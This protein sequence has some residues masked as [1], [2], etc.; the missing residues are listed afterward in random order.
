VT[1][2]ACAALLPAGAHFCPSCGAQVGAHALGRTEVRKTV[3]V[4]FCDMVGS[5]ALSQ[6]LD[7]EPLHMLMQQYF[8]LMRD[9]LQRHGGFVEKYIGDAVVAIFGVPT[10]HEDDALRAVRAAAEMQAAIVRLSKQTEREF[11]VPLSVRIGVNTGPVIAVAPGDAQ[12]TVVGETVNVAA[13]LEQHADPGQVLLGELTCQAVRGTAEFSMGEPLALKGIAHPVTPGRLVAITSVSHR[14]S[15]QPDRAFVDRRTEVA[16]LHTA[17]RH[18]VGEQRLRMVILHGDP[19]I[20]KSRL[21]R[22]FTEWARKAGAVVGEGHCPGYGSGGS[23]LALA[24]ALRQVLKDQTSTSPEFAEASKIL[25][26]SLLA[27]GSPG[28]VPS[29]TA[30]AV[31]TVLTEIGRVRPVVLI[32][33]DLHW[34]DS[35]LLAVIAGLVGRPGGIPAVMLCLGR[36]EFAA[37]QAGWVGDLPNVQSAMVGPL[38]E[39]ACLQLAAAL[40]EVVAHGADV[41]K[42]AVRRAEGNPLYVEQFITAG[43]TEVTPA[44][45]LYVAGPV[46]G[47]SGSRD[48]TPIPVTVS[49]LIAY[50]LDLL[51]AAER[52]VLSLGAVCGRWFTLREVIAAADP[53]TMPWRAAARSGGLQAVELE[54][55]LDSLAGRRLIQPSAPPADGYRFDSA[56]IHEV[57]YGSIPKRRRAAAHERL[58]RWLADS[59]GHG[60]D[61]GTDAESIGSHWERAWQLRRELRLPKATYWALASRGAEALEAAGTASLAN[62][63]PRHAIGL[64]DRAMVLAQAGAPDGMQITEASN[65]GIGSGSRIPR[66]LLKAGEARLVVGDIQAGRQLIEDADDQASATDDHLVKAHAE[67]QLA[68]LNPVGQFTRSLAAARRALPVFEAAGDRLGAA[69]ALLRIGIVEQSRGRHVRAVAAMER[70]LAEAR[71]LDAELEHATVVGALGVSLWLGPQQAA[72]AIGTCR[73]LL[74]ADAA[75]RRLVRVALLCPL[76]MLTGMTGNHQQAASLLADAEVIVVGLGNAR[77]SAVLPIFSA[78]AKSLAGDL[79]ASESLLLQAHARCLDI[80]DTQLAESAQRD[81]SRVRLLLGADDAA[82]DLAARA[83][84]DDVPAAV[85]DRCGVR[86]RVAARRGEEAQARNLAELALRAARR[87]DSPACKATALLDVAIAMRDLGDQSAEGLAER[88][89]RSFSSK[90]HQV[91]VGWAT[92]F[93]R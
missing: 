6:R 22:E 30:W 83:V 68:Y 54:E 70:A 49:G 16:L 77:A 86:A 72:Q 34:A 35:A 63:D 45:W 18:A 40:G 21:A 56:L 11:G 1:C 39:D 4:L 59:R 5:T 65:P 57:V 87:T 19:G 27:D 71:H 26:R 64:L 76:A 88:A 38:P 80:R 43:M 62:G 42:W 25:R 41:A 17:F 81:L 15:R 84:P 73:S 29:E 33:D 32:M 50:R 44:S 3:T 28:L 79:A 37:K 51:A 24:E 23:A 31:R 91:G 2:V 7:P 36:P 90:G 89:V 13:R 66:L 85:A 47:D 48:V 78:T 67:I 60:V 58:A 14:G 52:E 55:V 53:D 8:T 75:G 9:C 12:S 69:R 92:E 61:P 46:R 74:A 10:V 82:D 20:G 93:L